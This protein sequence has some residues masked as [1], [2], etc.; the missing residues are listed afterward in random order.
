M[1]GDQLAAKECYLAMLAMDKHVQMMSIDER[2]VT[3]Y[4]GAHGSIERCS[5]GQKQPRQ[6]HKDWNKH[7]N[8]DESRRCLSFKEEHGCVHIESRGYVGY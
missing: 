1:Q 4:H 2:K 7:G 6:V 3:S 5:F 8:K